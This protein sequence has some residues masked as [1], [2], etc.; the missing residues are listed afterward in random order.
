MDIPGILARLRSVA[1]EED[2]P[3][4][5]RTMTYN[6]RLAQELGKWA[7][8]Q[9]LGDEF[10][11]AAFRAYFADGKNIA[12]VPVLV[13]LAESVG[14]DG[15]AARKVLEERSF[16]EAVDADWARARMIGVSAVPTFVMGT[17][18]LVGAQPYD[19][20]ARFLETNGV[21]AR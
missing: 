17:R 15:E 13:E 16:D 20:I 5:D 4:G 3:F 18:G 21:P 7:E 14:L 12:Q 10:H 2:L 1:D 19:T 11:D 9:S 8:S 6:S